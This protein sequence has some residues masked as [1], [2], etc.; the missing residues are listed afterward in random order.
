MT[1]HSSQDFTPVN[2]HLVS[3]C[4]KFSSDFIDVVHALLD[5]SSL[6]LQARC[7]V[8]GTQPLKA[9]ARS[10]RFGPVS[11]PCEV[12]I[13]IYG[14]QALMDNVG[15]FFQEVE[16]YL[17]DPNGC[18]WDV[19]YCNPHRL[20]SLNINDCPMTSELGRPGTELDQIM[21]QSIPGESDVL[22]VLDAHRDL[23]EAPQPALIRSFLQK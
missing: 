8:G 11:L 5:E 1:I 18:D 9:A 21:F 16:M 12:S 3:G 13:I 4:G 2:P 19:R 17:Q 15:E 10:A 22:D 20:S 23:P 6:R 14:P 7:T